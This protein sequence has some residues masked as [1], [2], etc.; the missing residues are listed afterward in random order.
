MDAMKNGY[1]LIKNFLTKEERE[2]LTHYT[3]LKH[4]TNFDS[5]DMAQSDQGDTM[6]Y[7]DPVTDSLLITKKDLMERETGLKLLPTYTFWRMYSYGADLKKHTDRPSCEY[8]VTVKISSCGVK[9]PIFMAGAEMELEDGD[10]VIYKGCDLEHWREEFKGD[11]H[12]QVFIHYVNKNGPHREWF[13]DKRV[14]L[15]TL[16]Q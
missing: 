7:G 14:M 10:A 12:S 2:L 4:R 15:G 3:R 13:K 16:K 6:F 9:W 8:S 11:W 1:K 5:F